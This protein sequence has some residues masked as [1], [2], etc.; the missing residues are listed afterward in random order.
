MPAA[1]GLHGAPARC[2][3][4]SDSPV[5]LM[6]MLGGLSE[7]AHMP[8][9]QLLE[10][11]GWRGEAFPGVEKTSFGGESCANPGTL[12]FSWTFSRYPPCSPGPFLIAAKVLRRTLRSL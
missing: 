3:E 7:V 11:D 2:P 9:G 12:G 4:A 6:S 8:N 1:G 5:S 10:C